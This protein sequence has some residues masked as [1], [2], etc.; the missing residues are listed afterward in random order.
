MSPS[1]CSWFASPFRLPCAD[2]ASDRLFDKLTSVMSVGAPDTPFPQR[3]E[4]SVASPSNH[5]LHSLPE[6]NDAASHS[7]PDHG[8]VDVEGP[9][10]DIALMD[11]VVDDLSAEGDRLTDIGGSHAGGL[12]VGSAS[13]LSR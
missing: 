1:P 7:F 4:Y 12:D 10:G 2:A 9:T 5:S 3:R 8:H 6:L 13:V 11:D